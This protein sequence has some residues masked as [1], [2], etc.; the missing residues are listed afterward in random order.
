MITKSKIEQKIFDRISADFIVDGKL[1]YAGELLQLACKRF[2]NRVALICEDQTITYKELYFRSILLGQ[3]LKTLKV[4]SRDRVLLYFENSVDFYI[5][6]FAILQVGAVVV[7]L[8]VYLHPKELAHIV[9]DSGANLAI[10]S[11]TLKPTWDKLTEMQ[12]VDS[13]KLPQVL[14]QDSIDLQAS[15]P[16]NFEEIFDSFKIEKLE[17]EELTLLLYTSGTTG[18]P[19]GVMLSSQNMIYN[20]MQAY[21][22]LTVLGKTKKKYF[23]LFF[24]FF[25]ALLN[26]HVFGYL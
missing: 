9:K 12:L 22:R 14:S 6:Y 11:N 16:E 5:A 26:A 10:V 21:A 8:N 19:K 20:A 25:T 7:P 13:E 15:V 3:K 24:R 18:V 2:A 23:F 4:N 17:T 1:I